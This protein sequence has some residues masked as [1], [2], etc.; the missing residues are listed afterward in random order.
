[1]DIVNIKYIWTFAITI[2]IVFSFN[3][4]RRPI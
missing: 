1:M 2:I 3:F 4:L